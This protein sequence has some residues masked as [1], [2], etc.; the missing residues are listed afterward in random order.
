MLR[1][2]E[3]AWQRLPTAWFQLTSSIRSVVTCLRTHAAD[4]TMEIVFIRQSVIS[5][6]PPPAGSELSSTPHLQS[7]PRRPNNRLVCNCGLKQKCC[8]LIDARDTAAPYLHQFVCVVDVP[9]RLRFGLSLCRLLIVNGPW[10]SG[11]F[12]SVTMHVCMVASLFVCGTVYQ[13]TTLRHRR[14]LFSRSNWK[15]IYFGFHFHNLLLDLFPLM[16]LVVAWANWATLKI[17]IDWLRRS[18][19]CNL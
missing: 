5:D 3:S 1:C 17:S 13:P 8:I 2:V 15:F 16:V 12:L 9:T 14:W 6:S 19:W 18:E 7:G 11:S 10:L 4:R